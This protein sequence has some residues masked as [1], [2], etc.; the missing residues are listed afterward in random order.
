[1]FYASLRVFVRFPI[2]AVR[3]H[4]DGKSEVIR[5][6]FIFIGNNEYKMEFLSPGSR[7]SLKKC[8]LSLYIA[9]TRTRFGILKIVA[10]L[11]LNYFIPFTI[12]EMKLVNE[13]E[14]ESRKKRIHVAV[15]GEVE[16][17]EPPLKYTIQ[18][19]SIKV[20][21]PKENDDNV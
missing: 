21:I 5:S 17:L 8:V 9:R 18:P 11:I 20:I 16:Y 19:G 6:P 15:D 14:I 1:M 4:T 2:Y 3:I 12:F 10:K 13:I 7:D